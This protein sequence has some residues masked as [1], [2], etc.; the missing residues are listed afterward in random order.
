M[1]TQIPKGYQEWFSVVMRKMPHLSKSQAVGLA[2]GRFGIAI[3]LSLWIINSS[4][5]FSRNP[6][7]ISKQ[8]QRAVKAMVQGKKSQIWQKATGNRSQ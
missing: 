4:S 5:V 3:T 6:T 8:C 2:M 1:I 7:S